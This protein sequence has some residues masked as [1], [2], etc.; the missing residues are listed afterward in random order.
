MALIVLSIDCGGLTITDD[1]IRQRMHE[2]NPE[3]AK[4]VPAT[5]VFGTFR[6]YVFFHFHSIRIH[7]WL[8]R[9]SF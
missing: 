4:K 9:S 3:E 8:Y 7:P 6:E 5:Q 2:R 1:D